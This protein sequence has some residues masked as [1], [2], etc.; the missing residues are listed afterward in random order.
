MNSLNQHLG[1][2]LEL[3]IAPVRPERPLRRAVNGLI[4]M[5]RLMERWHLRAKERRKLATLPPY[6]LKDIGLTE[7]DRYREMHKRF[8]EE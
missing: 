6:I 8:W 7:A 5:V 4:G 2:H 1:K 3:P